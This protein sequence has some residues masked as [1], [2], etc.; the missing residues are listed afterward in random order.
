MFAISIAIPPI[1]IAWAGLSLLIGLLALTKRRSFVLGC[2]QAFCLRGRRPFLST[3]CGK[4]GGQEGQ[5]AS[6]STSVAGRTFVGAESYQ[7]GGVLG[8][9]KTYH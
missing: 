4:V 7:R 9:E 3:T 5:A 6:S 2:G 1:A 8:E